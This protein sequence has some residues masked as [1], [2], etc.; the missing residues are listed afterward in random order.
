[1]SDLLQKMLS[2]RPWLLAD[3]ATGTNF[4]TVGLPTGHAPEL[5]NLDEPDKV[6][7]QY[8]SFVDAGSDIFLTNSF[9]GTRNRLK[10]HQ[11]EDQVAEVS[12]AAA[13]LAREVAGQAG[14]EI[15]VDP[16]GWHFGISGQGRLSG[17]SPKAYVRFSAKHGANGF[18]VVGHY[19][20]ADDPPPAPLEI[21]HFWYEVDPRVGR[22]LKSHRHVTNDLACEYVVR[23]D[24]EPHDERIEMRVPSLK[25]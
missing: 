5:W 3:G 21:E 1:M 19:V 13:R 14:R 8:R 10:L 4:F 24:N 15:V 20:P 16:N 7:D 6:R 23:C 22:R 18:R 25:S 9:G 2:E 17:R 12:M 11:A